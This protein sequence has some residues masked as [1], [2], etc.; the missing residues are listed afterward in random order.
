MKKLIAIPTIVIA[1]FCVLAF[2]Q[3]AVT[4]DAIPTLT[5]PDFSKS[6]AYPVLRVIDGD[7]IVVDSNGL[8]ITVRL[9]GIDTP[10][11]KHP[12][13]PVQYYGK[14]ASR[15]TDNLLKG[16]KVYLVGDTE[17]DKIDKYGRTLAHVYRA[18][19]GLFVNAE[20]IRQGYGHAYTRFP[21]KYMEEFKQLER[22]ARKAEKG[23]WGPVPPVVTL[24]G[25]GQSDAAEYTYVASVNSEVFHKPTC[26][27]AK[28]IREHNLIGFESRE[29]AVN[30]GRR[31][32]KVCRP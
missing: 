3:L 31:L 1:I 10:E 26:R 28:Q 7:T 6:I 30:T 15:F 17:G 23:L 16:E 24:K 8:K 5:T 19:D 29:N 20:I 27:S 2:T 25:K 32:C 4:S 21:F 14:E 9:I 12:T 11:T 13:K 22:F 18:P